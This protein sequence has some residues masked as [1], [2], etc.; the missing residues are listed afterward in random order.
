VSAKDAAG[1]G[2][3]DLAGVGAKSEALFRE[4][5][6]E[7]ARDLLEYLPFRYEDLRH[8]TPAAMLGSSG[9]EENAVGRI[10]GIKERRVRGLEIVDVQLV[11]D[12]GDG[13]A[14]KWIG[15][16]RY[17]YGRFHEGMRLFVRGRVE[18]TLSGPIVAV[19]QYA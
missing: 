12:R 18:R 1:V 11:D 16:N 13:F 8:P 5:G 4:L 19:S 15:R 3:G 17:V 10:V 7:T 9:A 14:A 2:I 6:I